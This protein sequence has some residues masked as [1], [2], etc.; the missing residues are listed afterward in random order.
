MGRIRRAAIFGYNLRRQE[1]AT[2]VTSTDKV[3]L[4]FAGSG[5][6]SARQRQAGGEARVARSAN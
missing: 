4:I 6:P 2:A 3:Y 5:P 1:K